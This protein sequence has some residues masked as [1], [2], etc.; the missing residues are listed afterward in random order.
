MNNIAIEIMSPRSLS[1]DANNGSQGHSPNKHN[2]ALGGMSYIRV[3]TVNEFT[4]R[5]NQI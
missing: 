2:H 3:H 4:L 1:I 5:K